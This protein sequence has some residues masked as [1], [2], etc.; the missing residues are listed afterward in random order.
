MQSEEKRLMS[1][2]LSVLTERGKRF[3]EIENAQHGGNW[4]SPF[5]TRRRP[6]AA[7][8][9]EEKPEQKHIEKESVKC[10]HSSPGKNSS[11]KKKG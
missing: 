1:R 10:Q 4:D 8:S 6:L 5:K 3:E 7:R 9:T 2:Y 11:K